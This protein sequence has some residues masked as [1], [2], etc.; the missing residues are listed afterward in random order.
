[1]KF[2]GLTLSR[3]LCSAIPRHMQT[4]QP[5]WEKHLAEHLPPSLIPDSGLVQC[6]LPMVGAPLAEFEAPLLHGHTQI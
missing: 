6:Q 5:K 1:M 2:T 3:F 4:C